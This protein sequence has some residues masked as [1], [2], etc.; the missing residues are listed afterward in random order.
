MPKQEQA[1][2][3]ARAVARAEEGSAEQ[4]AGRGGL[5]AATAMYCVGFVARFVAPFEVNAEAGAIKRPS[6]SCSSPACSN[7]NTEN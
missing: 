2:V 6:V 1:L 3:H 4:I 5:Q 7:S